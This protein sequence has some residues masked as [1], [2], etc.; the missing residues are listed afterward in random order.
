MSQFVDY[1]GFTFDDVLL[2]PNFSEVLPAEVLVN[3]RLTPE[4][5]LSIPLCSAAMDTVTEGRLAIAIAREGGVGII[6][7]NLTI[8]EQAFEVD[9]VKRSEAG[10]ITN[11]FSLHPENTIKEADELMGHYHISGVPIVDQTNKLVGI[12]TNRDL[13]F[14]QDYD[15]PIKNVMTSTNLITAPEGTTLADAEN[16]LRHHKVEKL[17]IV[18]WDGRLKGLITIK[19]LQKVKDYPLAAKD[20][21]GRLRAGASVG[22][23]A[24]ALD[25]VDA[26]VAAHV[27]VIV[28]DT[29]HGHSAKV[30]EM[31]RRIKQRHPDLQLIGGNIATAAAAQA[32]LEA[33]VDAVK[34]G[35]GPGS[36]CT[37]RIVAGI[38][39]PQLA[40]VL[41]VAAKMRGTG[42][43]VIADGGIRYSGD[44]VKALAAG[45]NS[46]MIG[47]LL[48]G[49]EES[50]GEVII[51][52]GRSYKS[53]RGMGSLGAMKGGS[54]KDR[55]FQEGSKDNKLV[56]EGI[57]GLAAFK[58]SA[59]DVI[60]QLIG[61][62]RSGMGYLGAHNLQELTDNARFIQISA[63]SVRENHPHDVVVTKEAPNYWVE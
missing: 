45:A 12:L 16:V 31:V 57:E 48:A 38:G 40:A 18:D 39:V 61:G 62:L 46:V 50:P 8:E 32:L 20:S 63:A 25:R 17:P 56:P 58:G 51:Y 6:H 33:G 42:R 5:E 24:D 41:N 4:I 47:S 55:Y 7:R 52:R 29:A 1:Q 9:K 21:G 26:L 23:G 14:V 15:Q 54:C 59:H 11:P 10:V 53:Y 28:V 49:T 44:M 27:D 34:V 60:Y 22:V 43:C 19:D 36:I 37:T 3:S 35:V 30:L 2:E 13:R